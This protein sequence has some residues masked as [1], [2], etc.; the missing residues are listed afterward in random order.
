[1]MERR[2]MEINTTGAS[3]KTE[4]YPNKKSTSYI[5]LLIKLIVDMEKRPR[6]K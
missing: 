5:L 4:I 3:Q 2:P 6:V 1:M